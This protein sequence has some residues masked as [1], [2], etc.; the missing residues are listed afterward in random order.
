MK[1]PT[2]VEDLEDFDNS[3]DDNNGSFAVCSLSILVVL[4]VI[5]LCYMMSI[6]FLEQFWSRSKYSAGLLP[7]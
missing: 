2:L 4:T 3:N 1:R 6:Q 5:T 7:L